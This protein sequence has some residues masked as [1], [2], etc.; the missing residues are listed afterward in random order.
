MKHELS[1]RSNARRNATGENARYVANIPEKH[2]GLI[3]IQPS[4][5]EADKTKLP[6]RQFLVFTSNWPEIHK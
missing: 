4:A 3:S 1:H 5:A 6:G 2:R